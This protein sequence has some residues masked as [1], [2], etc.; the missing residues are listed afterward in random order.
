M[1]RP[2]KRLPANGL[3]IIRDLASHGVQETVLAKALGLDVK[4]WRKIRTED[5]DAKAAWEEARATE[6]DRL[7]GELF[8]QAVG[9]PAQYDAEGN[10]IQAEQK[11]NPS[12]AMFLLKTRHG[13]REQ[14]PADGDDSPR[15]NLTFNLPAPLEP[16]QWQKLVQAHPQ[17]LGAPEQ[18]RAA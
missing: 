13:Y 14:G 2:R 5:P 16:E 4:T 18:D 12:A 17:A 3:D 1:A 8:A 15:V 7:V 11:P 9:R 10:V 6:E